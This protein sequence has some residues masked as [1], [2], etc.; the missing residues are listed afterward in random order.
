M[1]T[2]AF[3][4][5]FMVAFIT[6][7]A[8][9]PLR[10]VEERAADYAEFLTNVT[11]Q[12]RHGDVVRDSLDGFRKTEDYSPEA[13]LKALVSIVERD[14]TSTN[15]ESLRMAGAAIHA[16]GYMQLTNALPM[17]KKWTLAGGDVATSSFNAYGRIA[18]YDEQ[19]LELGISAVNPKAL[20]ESFF[21]GKLCTRLSLDN[22]LVNGQ[23]L[24][25]RHRLNEK[26]KC[27]MARIVINFEDASFES[28]MNNEEVFARCIDGY[29]N[30][31]EHVRAQQ[32]INDFLL[33]RKEHILK[34]SACRIIGKNRLLSDEEW[35][36]RTTN[37]CQSEI[38]RVMALPEDERLNMTAILDAKIAAIEAVEARAVCRAVWKRRLRIGGYL[39]LPVLGIVAAA[40]VSRRRRTRCI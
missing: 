37:N 21:F 39:L 40:I 4:L 14:R 20:G 32:R 12:L 35:Y 5:S 30:S 36:R 22:S 7:G 24:P 6:F 25:Q 34:K 3:T 38:A 33:Q 23:Q 9:G 1:K 19:Y 27:K 15:A 17:L 2:L 28:S 13:M 31:I 18:G 11:F 29:T 10:S 16:M 26:V 8:D